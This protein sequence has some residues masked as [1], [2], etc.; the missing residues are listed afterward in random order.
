M[1]VLRDAEWMRLD[2]IAERR[3]EETPVGPECDLEF[4]ER[5]FAGTRWDQVL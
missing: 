3:R 5:D 4:G 1:L 2:V